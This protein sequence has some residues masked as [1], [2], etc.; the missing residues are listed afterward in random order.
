MQK[1]YI[2]PIFD[3]KNGIV[4]FLGTIKEVNDVLANLWVDVND[5][6]VKENPNVT[7]SI[8]DGINKQV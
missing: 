7:I 4:S 6:S 5:T 8:D 2:V 3:D 1:N